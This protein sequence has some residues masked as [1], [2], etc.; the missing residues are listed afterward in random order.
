MSKKRHQLDDKARIHTHLVEELAYRMV[1][2]DQ[3]DLATLAAIA[4]RFQATA[5]DLAGE[6]WLEQFDNHI[7][8]LVAFAHKEVPELEISNH[9]M[10]LYP[11]DSKK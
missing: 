6:N 11:A 4:S 1:S 3:E 7:P 8:A 9:R 5:P 10:P 2:F